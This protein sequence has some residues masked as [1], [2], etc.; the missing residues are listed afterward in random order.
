LEAQLES[1]A[2]SFLEI[3]TQ[4]SLDVANFHHVDCGQNFFQ[5]L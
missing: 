4:L 1:G 5:Q 2:D 3:T